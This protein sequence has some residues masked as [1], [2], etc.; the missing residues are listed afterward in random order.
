MRAPF[1]RTFWILLSW[2]GAHPD[3]LA[4]ADLLLGAWCL[5][6]HWFCRYNQTRG[7]LGTPS[8]VT[9]S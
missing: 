7:L 5:L 6:F 3:M 2:H 9:G 1:R 4:E 8:G